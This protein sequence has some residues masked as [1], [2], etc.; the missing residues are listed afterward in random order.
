MAL[1]L[2]LEALASAPRERRDGVGYDP[3]PQMTE[4]DYLYL[5]AH[6]ARRMMWFMAN[7]LEH[8]PLT[9]SPMLAEESRVW[10]EKLL[11]NCSGAGIEH[12]RGVAEGENLAKNTGTVNAQGGGWG[13]VRVKGCFLCSSR[14]CDDDDDE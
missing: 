3:S 12:E 7:E 4:R 13:Q 14:M 8:V 11:V 9:W 1:A 2:A 5:E 10:A 6:N